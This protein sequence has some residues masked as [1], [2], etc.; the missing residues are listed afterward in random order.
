MCIRDRI[1]DFLDFLGFQRF[2]ADLAL[3]VLAALAVGGRLLVDDPVTGL[4]ACRLGVVALVG[5]AAAGAGVGGV[6]H[7]RTGRLGHNGFIVMTQSVLNDGPTAGAELGIG[8]GGRVAGDMACGLI[9]LQT[10]GSTADAGVL[11]HALAGAGGVGDLLALVPTVAQRVGIVGDERTAA[12]LA[13]M[14][15]SLIHI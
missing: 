1:V 11:G 7:L 13:D 8:A 2:T 6:A 5:V 9:A 10:G 4:V 15:L 14:E 3:L 12:A